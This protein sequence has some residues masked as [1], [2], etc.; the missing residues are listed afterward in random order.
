MYI[1]LPVRI[2]MHQLVCI[3]NMSYD[4]R[5]I[6][7]STAAFGTIHILR[8]HLYDQPQHFHEFFEQFFCTNN[9]KLQHENFVKM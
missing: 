3:L 2:E 4:L 6:A 9:F 5:R 8:K 1:A 7:T